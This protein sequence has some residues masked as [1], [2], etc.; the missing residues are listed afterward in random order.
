M[1]GSSEDNADITK[2][3]YEAEAVEYTTTINQWC[4]KTGKKL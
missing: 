4:S 2:E 3:V 1:A